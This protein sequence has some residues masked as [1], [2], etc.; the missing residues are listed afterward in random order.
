MKI[1]WAQDFAPYHKKY[2]AP[3]V[4]M[5]LMAFSFMANLG[6]LCVIV[7]GVLEF[8]FELTNKLIR[9]LDLVYF[10]AWSM[11]LIERVGRIIL[12]KP[13]K[14]KSAFS[15]LGWI[16]NGLLMLTLIPIIVEFFKIDHNIGLISILGNREAH[17]LILFLI[18]LIEL[19]NTVITSMG[20]KTN[21]ALAMAV[22]FM[23]IIL[24]GSGLLLMPRCIQPGVHLSW[25]DSLFTATSAVCVTGLTTIDVPS[26]FTSFGQMVI[27][28]LIQ[29]GG[30]GIMT[31]TSFFA[32]FFMS[33]TSIYSQM[34]VRDMVSSK[35][36]ASLWSTL[37]NIFGFTAALEL[38]GAVCI[39]L[40]IHG[41]IGLDLRHELFFS[42]FHSVSAFC[43]AGFS[44]YP[45]GMSAPELMVGGHCWLYVILSLLI[46]LGG[47]GYPVLVN[48]KAVVTKRA[49]LIW[50]WLRG[51]RYA[52]LS[53][54]NLYDLNT[55][56]VL[57]TTAVL[58]VS[59]TVLIAFFEWDN[60][61]AGMHTHEKLTQAFFNAVSPRTAGFI[62]V[63]L[64]SM[65]LQSI[66]IYTLLMWIGG[67]SQSTAGGVKVNAFAVAI[68]N[69]RS[70]LR[71]SDRVEFA[72]RAVSTDSIRRANA[73]VIVSV[74]V[75]SF[76]VFLVTLTDPD[77]PLKAIVFECVSA[78]ATVGSSLGIT[79]QLQD[80]S[81]VLLVVLMF[82][83]RVGVVT[84]A[85]GLLKQY[86]NQNYYKLPQD[87]ITIS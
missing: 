42:V 39:F 86:K 79:S 40:N 82:I 78:F 1:L 18:A 12:T 31:I 9:E 56:I 11:F 65:C 50:R 30:L 38:A 81:K 73:A 36:L 10:W 66:F 71:G 75:L 62:S 59:G 32:L 24:A 57:K 23:F 21:P 47:I 4:D 63:N 16:I 54:P 19:S 43:N 55:K 74:V 45:D 25:I 77:L 67:A 70:I 46:I 83:G 61:F 68:L 34:L 51:R 33:N 80:A 7:G 41:T 87:N 29:V 58:I 69:I 52:S 15:F 64:N 49:R 22:S 13:G 5:A 35:S 2:V 3:Y 60:T 76:F 17:L 72:G 85:Q 26:T 20:R 27:I 14:R 6:A 84:L 28:M 37:L 8:G 53:I 44:N 48:M